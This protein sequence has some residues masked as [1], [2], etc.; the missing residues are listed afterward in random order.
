VLLSPDSSKPDALRSSSHP[1]S[2]SYSQVVH[3]VTD[4]P[5]KGDEFHHFAGTP[6]VVTSP[7]T[8]HP[9]SSVAISSFPACGRSRI[10]IVDTSQTHQAASTR[11]RA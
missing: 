10:Y 7:L 9:S 2:Q 4:G 6:V 3:T 11:S 1:S 5:N 8:G